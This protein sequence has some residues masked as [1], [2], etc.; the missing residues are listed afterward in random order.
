MLCV[1]TMLNGA[2]S[3][4]QAEAWY[5]VR[6]KYLQPGPESG[7]VYWARP[8]TGDPAALGVRLQLA[9]ACWGVSPPPLPGSEEDRVWGRI[10]TQTAAE[11][12]D[13]A[14]MEDACS[15]HGVDDPRVYGPILSAAARR[16]D[17]ACVRTLL[18]LV[19]WEVTANAY[20]ECQGAAL[21]YPLS[22]ESRREMAT[23]VL[24]EI[25]VP[26]CYRVEVAKA[27]AL[28][29]VDPEENCRMALKKSATIKTRR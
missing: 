8:R 23:Y 9:L 12:G 28:V 26:E 5:G 20:L 11:R 17:V 6:R 1:D 25:P 18:R 19:G 24:A 7:E 29:L 21:G 14:A 3:P 16:G 10:L 2:K 27:L 4:E 13:I 15:Q 22:R